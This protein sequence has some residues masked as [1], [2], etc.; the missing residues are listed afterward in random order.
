MSAFI[1]GP[2]AAIAP[3]DAPLASAMDEPRAIVP[4]PRLLVMQLQMLALEPGVSAL[5]LGSTGGYVE[6]LLARL[7][8][9]GPVTVWEED[10]ALAEIAQRALAANGFADRVSFLP[11]PPEG[12]RFDR[13]TTAEQ[14]VRIDPIARA[15]LADMGF[16]LYRAHREDLQFVKLLRSG[17]EYLELATSEGAERRDISSGVRRQTGTDI[18]RELALG[19][20][21]ENAWSRRE[22]TEHDRQFCEVVDETFPPANDLPGLGAEGPAYEAARM[23]FHLAYIYQAAGE[24]DT[25]IE[26]YRA[27]LTVRPTAEAHTFLGWVYSFQGR[28]TDAIAECEKAIAV[29]PTFGNPYNDIGAYLI[30]LDRLDEAIPWFEKAKASKRYCCYFYPYSNLG[31]VY[32]M[33][34]MHA[35]A[36]REFEEALRI[37]PRY[38]FAREM[39]KRVERGSDYIA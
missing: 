36:R 15:M 28:P 38:E 11:G 17:D 6:A 23:M 9:R 13:I 25:A 30:E 4:P 33:K 39:L 12:A 22:E 37:N 8:D 3:V 24:W 35:K 21:L 34:G 20:M 26:L 2:L 14:I 7:V 27:S 10:R 31:R 1:G 16:A 19:R 32:L 5:L 18:G 29:D